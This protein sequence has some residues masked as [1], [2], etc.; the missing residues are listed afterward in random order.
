MAG[1]TRAEKLSDCNVGVTKSQL[2]AMRLE[3]GYVQLQIIA[4][5]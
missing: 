4:N 3:Y 1:F 2:R 5:L